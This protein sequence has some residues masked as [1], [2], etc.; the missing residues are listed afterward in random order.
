MIAVALFAVALALSCSPP[1]DTP[2]RPS[3]AENAGTPTPDATSA[4][5]TQEPTLPPPGA[6]GMICR[7]N[8]PFWSLEISGERAVLQTP[9]SQKESAQVFTG[10]GS[11]DESG[12]LIWE[13]AGDAGK[14][15]ICIEERECR[16]TMSDETPPTPFSAIATLPNGAEGPGCCQVL[17]R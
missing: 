11:R 16:D 8:E 7:G 10:A 1:P 5:P 3:S 15:R 14:V 17:A 12:A 4:A 6:I 13:G 2:A 9:E